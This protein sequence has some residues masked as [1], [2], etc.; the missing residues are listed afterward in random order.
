M[1]DTLRKVT[2]DVA[3]NT[4]REV[5]SHTVDLKSF[6]ISAPKKVESWF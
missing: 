5:K 4:V 2:K 3:R 1:E 6:H